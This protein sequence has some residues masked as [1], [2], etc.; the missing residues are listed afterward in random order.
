MCVAS[1]GQM[2]TEPHGGRGLKDTHAAEQ[3]TMVQ[4]AQAWICPSTRKM[5]AVSGALQ[6]AAKED[7]VYCDTAALHAVFV[8]RCVPRAVPHNHCCRA[9]AN[10][11]DRIKESLTLS[12]QQQLTA[13]PEPQG[14]SPL[15]LSQT[16][17]HISH[18]TAQ[19]STAQGRS[20]AAY[21]A[22]C[23]P[24]RHTQHHGS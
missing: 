18:S 10:P 9:K 13:D 1:V 7:G 17:A 19:H 6:L 20:V 4:P 23:L 15:L 3:E 22:S 11:V 16:E 14:S 24:S 2:C 12:E 5:C 8:L 21:I